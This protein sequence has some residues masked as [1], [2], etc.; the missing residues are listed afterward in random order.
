MELEH[1]NF[2]QTL[3]SCVDPEGA[4]AMGPELTP[5]KITKLY[6]YLGRLV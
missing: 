2:K 3:P 6:V 5:L 1:H 4:W